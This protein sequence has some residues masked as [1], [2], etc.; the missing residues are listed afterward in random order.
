MGAHM[1]P[2]RER[3]R[4]MRRSI[5]FTATAIIAIPVLAVVAMW[6]FAGATISDA[7]ANHAQ[8]AHRGRRHGVVR[9]SPL[10]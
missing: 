7:I 9:A 2:G 3:S 1:L 5:R 10:P 6:V 8:A 4:A